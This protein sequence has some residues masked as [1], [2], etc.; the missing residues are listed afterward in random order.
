MEVGRG[1]GEGGRRRR[2]GHFVSYWVAADWVTDWSHCHHLGVRGVAPLF[3]L[4]CQET[5]L[6]G[7]MA[8]FHLYPLAAPPRRC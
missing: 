3:V 5:A 6:C 1:R 4:S 8:D 2:A 7:P